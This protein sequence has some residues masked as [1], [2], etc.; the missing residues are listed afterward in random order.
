MHTDELFI[1]KKDKGPIH[2]PPHLVQRPFLLEL[3][4]WGALVTSM[5][6][7]TFRAHSS[8]TSTSDRHPSAPSPPFFSLRPRQH[9]RW[10]GEEPSAVNQPK[11]QT[12]VREIHHF[13]PPYYPRTHARTLTGS[14]QRAARPP[15]R[16]R[17]AAVGARTS[18]PGT[19]PP[20][21]PGAPSCAPPAPAAPVERGRGRGGLRER[22]GWWCGSPS[23]IPTNDRQIHDA[24]FKMYGPASTAPSARR[25]AAAAS[26]PRP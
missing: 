7:T 22:W 11:P 1:T 12:E 4:Y 8:Y 18:W 20:S 16:R 5:A 26:P 15:P 9:A 3:L 25:C 14:R 21:P 17:R 2:A 23:Q 6:C 19:P 24:F 13:P 10:E